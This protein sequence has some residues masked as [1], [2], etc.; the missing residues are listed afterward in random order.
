VFLAGDAAHQTPP[1]FSQG[2]CHGLRDVANLAWEAPARRSRRSTG[3][4]LET[5]QP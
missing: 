2:M 4:L 5:Y 3:S 1:F